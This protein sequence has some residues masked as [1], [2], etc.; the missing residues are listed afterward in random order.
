MPRS[1]NSAQWYVCNEVD[2]EAPIRYGYRFI[3]PTTQ[4]HYFIV[5][6]P[7]EISAVKTLGYEMVEF[8][9]KQAL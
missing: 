8:V 1:L 7:T 9:S 3:D 4:V 2:N 6:S 5:A